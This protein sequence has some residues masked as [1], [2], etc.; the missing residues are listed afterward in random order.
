MRIAVVPYCHCSVQLWVLDKSCLWVLCSGSHRGREREEMMG[1][2]FEDVVASAEAMGSEDVFQGG[3]GGADDCLRFFFMTHWRPFQSVSLQF[4]YQAVTQYVST[5]SEEQ[6]IESSSIDRSHSFKV[7]VGP[8][9]FF[10][11][12]QT[13]WLT[14][15]DSHQCGGLETYGI[16]GVCGEYTIGLRT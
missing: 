12:E 15:W 4:T 5:L 2:I 7:A 8:F 16:Y 13:S 9:L 11:P 14:I 6:W 1:H 10:L 3:Q